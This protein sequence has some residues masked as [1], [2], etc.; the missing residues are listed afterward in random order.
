MKHIVYQK[1]QLSRVLVAHTC[2]P[3]Y[4]GGWDWDGHSSRPV[5]ANSSWDPIWKT[6]KYQYIKGL[7]QSPEFKSSATKKKKE[8]KTE[9]GNNLKFI[10]H[11]MQLWRLQA[12]YRKTNQITTPCSKN[13][14][15]GEL[16]STPHFTLLWGSFAL[17][18][19]VPQAAPS[20]DTC[21]G[22][23]CTPC[24]LPLPFIPSSQ[25][26]GSFE[27]QQRREIHWEQFV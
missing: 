6:P 27:T 20:M 2:N 13:Y 1:D 10:N 16:Q 11:K 21:L 12:I 19:L 14:I 3:T 5:W 4:L 17:C 9:S 8:D 18:S 25:D 22:G 26:L 24:S 7:V 23:T 15:L